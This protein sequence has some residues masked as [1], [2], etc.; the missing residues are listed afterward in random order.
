[1]KNDYIIIE[2]EHLAA[3]ELQR[4]M[5]KLRPDYHLIGIGDSIR[6]TC[7]LLNNSSPNLILADI[8]LSDGLSFDIFFQIATDTPIIFTTA[9]DEYA[10]QA[11]R[12]NSV[13]YL[14]KPIDEEYLERALAK[15]EKYNQTTFAVEH[16]QHAASEYQSH[17]IKTRFLVQIGDEFRHVETKNIAYFYSEEKYTYLYTTQNKKYIIPYTL[18]SLQ[19]MID[20][21]QF[22]RISRNCICAIQGIARCSRYFSGRLCVQ[23]KPESPANIIVSRSRAADVLNWMDDK[24]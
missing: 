5:R 6:K 4:M 11:F 20:N 23:L 8:R 17:I 1:M 18:D 22:F 24:I 15:F 7:Q 10:I 21:K 16:L 2:D 9:Y 13:D 19:N 14:L 12:N 3:E